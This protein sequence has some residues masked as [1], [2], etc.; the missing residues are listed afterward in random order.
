MIKLLLVEDDKNLGYIM[1]GS[2]ED[3]IGGYEV[4]QALNGEEGITA[5]REHKPDFIVA[6]VDMPIMNGVEMVKKIREIDSQTPII[7]ASG[8]DSA[9]DVTVGYQCGVNNY[10]KKPFMP[11]ELDAHIQAIMRL[12]E[13][14]KP[15]T[16][17]KIYKIGL[18]TF[19]IEQLLLVSESKIKKLTAREAKILE[20]LYNN[21]GEV[22]RRDSIL[23]EI[24]GTN[25]FFNSRSLD[26]FIKKLRSYL[27]KDS[28][29]SI[30]TIKGLGL[31]LE[32]SALA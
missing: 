26:V 13:G 1:K 4:I 2:L 23:E 16:T 21:K 32:D 20:L 12:K 24:W 3:M 22:V 15:Q 6:D 29:I 10:I 9:K 17:Q 7:F 14:L 25:D 27:E 5:W 8:K 19:D 18:F 28:S 30:R 11:E 31:I